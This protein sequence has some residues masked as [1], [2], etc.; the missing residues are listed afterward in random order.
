MRF[1]YL[2]PIGLH[3]PFMPMGFAVRLVG[4]RM[5]RG[6]KMYGLIAD[7]LCIQ[8]IRSANGKSFISVNVVVC[9][10]LGATIARLLNWENGPIVNL[11][12]LFLIRWMTGSGFF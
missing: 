12:G 1:Q 3:A 2:R 10:G 11:D 6:Q 8:M 9:G 7:R 4:R 5:L